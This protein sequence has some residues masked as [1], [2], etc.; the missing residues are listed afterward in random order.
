MNGLV[1]VALRNS[2]GSQAQLLYRN[3]DNALYQEDNQQDQEENHNT[4]YDYQSFCQFPD[5]A[6][7]FLPGYIGHSHPVAARHSF[8]LNVGA[9]VK[10]QSGCTVS[11]LIQGEGV[12]TSH[13]FVKMFS[14]QRPVL[15]ADDNIGIG[16]YQEDSAG[17]FYSDR[18]DNVGDGIQVNVC[19]HHATNIVSAA[20]Q[21]AGRSYNI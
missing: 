13:Q 18:A 19:S 21:Y 4:G 8:H 7:N 3:T 1:Q 11:Y 2:S 20:L 17:F 6:Q 10:G 16:V 14:C 9:V 12:H 15:V 5:F